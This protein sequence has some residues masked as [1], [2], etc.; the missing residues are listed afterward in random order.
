MIFKMADGEQ[1]QI[2]APGLFHYNDLQRN[3]DKLFCASD[4]SAYY[5]KQVATA[6]WLMSQKAGND[7]TAAILLDGI[8]HSSGYRGELEG[9]HRIFKSIDYLDLTPS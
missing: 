3:S 2:K 1:K 5:K 9:L 7:C 4:G 6:G 8:N